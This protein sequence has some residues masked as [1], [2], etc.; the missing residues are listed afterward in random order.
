MR[1][2]LFSNPII[3]VQGLG[4]LEPILAAQG[5]RW[6]STLGL[7]H[8]SIIGLTHTHTYT[9]SDLDKIDTSVNLMSTSFEYGKKPED[10][11]KPMQT[12]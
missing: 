1:R 9:Y 2:Q 3:A 4:W 10:P 6:E 7:G 12:G 5:T 8:P 11:E